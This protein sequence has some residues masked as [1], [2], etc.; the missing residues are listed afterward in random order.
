MIILHTNKG[1]IK[2]ELDFDK[3]PVTAKTSSNTSKTA[4][5]TA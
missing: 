2:I 3:A 5:T 1:D 4:S